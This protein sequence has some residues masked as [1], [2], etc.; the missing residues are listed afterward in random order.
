MIQL[1]S[2]RT[3]AYHSQFCWEFEDIGRFLVFMLGNS[4]Q[5]KHQK[6]NWEIPSKKQM[7]QTWVDT[8]NIILFNQIDIF[9]ALNV[10]YAYQTS[11]LC[12]LSTYLSHLRQNS[13]FMSI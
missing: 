6:Q 7:Y 5:Q 12:Y 10:V 13:G 3:K 4:P 1:K 2:P 8:S 11:A 9:Q